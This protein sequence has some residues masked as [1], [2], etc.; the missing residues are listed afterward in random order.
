MDDQLRANHLLQ[1]L[2][3]ELGRATSSQG[4]RPHSLTGQLF[5][6]TYLSLSDWISASPPLNT[7]RMDDGFPEEA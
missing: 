4:V 3:R 6:L 5:G 1:A 2:E 7:G